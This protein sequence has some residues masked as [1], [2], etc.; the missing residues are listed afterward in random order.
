MVVGVV[1]RERGEKERETY[2]HD[3]GLCKGS[4]EAEV[5]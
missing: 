3:Y 4:S 5:D 2:L 1:E